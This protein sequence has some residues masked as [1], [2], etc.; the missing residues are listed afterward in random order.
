MKDSSVRG[1]DNGAWCAAGCKRN[2]RR[3][4]VPGLRLHLRDDFRD[5]RTSFLDDKVN[6]YERPILMLLNR[7][8]YLWTDGYPE[9]R[10][11]RTETELILK[12]RRVV[13]ARLM[14]SGFTFQFPSWRE[15]AR[16]L[17][18]RWQNT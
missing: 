13:P 5:V 14:Q 1:I 3:I 11:F 2:R 8:R 18:K 9:V 15:A 10:A 12:S 4:D 7:K 17:V 16:D 6:L